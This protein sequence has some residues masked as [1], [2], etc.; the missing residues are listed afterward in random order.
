MV[1]ESQYR[2]AARR[3]TAFA[4]HTVKS[5]IEYAGDANLSVF[6]LHVDLEKP[7]TKYAESS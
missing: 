5:V 6:L 4:S 1:G 3:G 7:S 2:A